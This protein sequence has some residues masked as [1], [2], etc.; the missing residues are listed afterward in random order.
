MHIIRYSA[1][2]CSLLNTVLSNAIP[3][4]PN[5]LQKRQNPAPGPLTT[6]QADG[7][8][9]AKNDLKI[10]VTD[11]NAE[12]A[13]N[14][15]LHKGQCQAAPSQPTT[16]RRDLSLEK[17]V[18]NVIECLI[19]DFQATL[20]E[21]VLNGLLAG[22]RDSALQVARTFPRPSFADQNFGE[23]FGQAVALAADRVPEVFPNIAQEQIGP[24]TIF[25]FFIAVAE[26]GQTFMQARKL[27]LQTKSLLT[28]KEFS[29]V[30]PKQGSTFYPKCDRLLC[31]GKDGKCTTDLMKPC[32]CDSGDK[33]DTGCSKDVKDM[34]SLNDPC[35]NCSA[36]T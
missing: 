23:A 36:M 18:P 10:E 12:K 1:L 32:G 2:A 29:L 31:Q 21:F 17:R 26:Y 11:D 3:P 9:H 6:V 30:C 16:P 8:G 25:I 35:W 33:K 27:Y 5:S 19:N 24:T 20:N 14:D 7:D 22:L 4:N 34:V 15:F 13:F 28:D